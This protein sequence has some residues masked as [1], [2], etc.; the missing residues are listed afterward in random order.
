[1]TNVSV[2]LLRV[3]TVQFV[4]SI[5]PDPGG[6]ESEVKAN[7]SSSKPQK[8]DCGIARLSSHITD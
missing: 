2:D 1:M 3:A 8:I 4:K 7:K 5:D 6:D